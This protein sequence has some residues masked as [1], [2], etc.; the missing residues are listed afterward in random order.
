MEGRQNRD[1]KT[2]QERKLGRGTIVCYL[3]IGT[4]LAI[5]RVALFAWLNHRNV[6]HTFTETDWYL[7]WACTPRPSLA[8]T[9]PSA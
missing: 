9:L 1:E 3:S 5:S 6:S 2:G 8:F 7:M 4:A